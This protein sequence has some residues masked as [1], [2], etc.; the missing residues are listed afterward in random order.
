[1]VHATVS[2][3]AMLAGFGTAYYQSAPEEFLIV[4]FFHGA[5]RFLNG[6]HLHKRKTFG[7]LIMPI[8]YDLCVLHMSNAVE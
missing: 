6:L 2:A 3:R 4:Q 8:A 1:M 5:F 7:A